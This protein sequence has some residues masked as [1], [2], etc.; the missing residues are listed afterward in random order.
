MPSPNITAVF[1]Q[2]AGKTLLN[3]GRI[4]A[5]VDTV[6]M[7]MEDVAK[8]NGVRLRVLF[9]DRMHTMDYRTDRINAHVV[10]NPNGTY[11]ISSF[12]IG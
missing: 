9:P 2:F 3:P 11:T 12:N 10:E 7:E 8:A 1:N 6:L 4:T 5:D